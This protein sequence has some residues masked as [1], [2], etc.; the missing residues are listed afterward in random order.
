MTDSMRHD[1]EQKQALSL[2]AVYSPRQP[3]DATHDRFLD[4]QQVVCFD[5]PWIGGSELVR[6]T[7]ELYHF[8]VEII[9]SPWTR[10]LDRASGS[11]VR[12]GGQLKPDRGVRRIYVS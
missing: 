11:I 9:R 3:D 4:L 2:C 6:P 5:E 7:Q 12:Q 10:F 8:R 1:D